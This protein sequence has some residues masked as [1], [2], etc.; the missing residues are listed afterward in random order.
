MKK[1]NK[2][3]SRKGQPRRQ[4]HLG[5][6]NMVLQVLIRRK[7][8]FQTAIAN[9]TN[10][11]LTAAMIGKA[12]VGFMALTATT[13]SFLS[14]NFRVNAISLWSPPPAVGSLT[15]NSLKWSD[16][17]AVSGLTG[18]G[19]FNGDS[20][21]E[22]DRPAYCHLKPAKGSPYA[23]FFSII[24]T[25]NFFVVTCPIGSILEIDFSHYLDNSGI[26][27]AGPVLVG[28]TAG[29]IYNATITLASG[30]LLVPNTSINTIAA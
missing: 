26:T 21:M 3:K 13:S 2:M 4:V 25:A 22:P 6:A 29:T 19:E 18:I 8:Q 10:N 16:T 24:G 17:N 15:Q 23:Q 7:I 1:N 20:S 12:C 14:T 9:T 28:A 27:P 11:V 30:A 5:P